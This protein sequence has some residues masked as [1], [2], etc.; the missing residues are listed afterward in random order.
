MVNPEI[1]NI[2]RQYL[3]ALPAIGINPTGAIL[4]GSQARGNTHEWSDIDVVII[5]PEFDEIRPIPLALA[6]KFWTTASQID[7]RL[8]P[9]PCG[10]NEW[11]QPHVRPVLS[12]AEAEGYEIAA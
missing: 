2:V 6:T 11:Q 4:F 8:E 10:T 12:Y 7:P 3:T 1:I 5:A 9:I